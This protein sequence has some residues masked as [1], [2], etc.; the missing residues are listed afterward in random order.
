MI[1]EK[2]AQ[3]PD[4]QEIFAGCI[5]LKE[6]H[7]SFALEDPSNKSP[8]TNVE[9]DS[10]ILSEIG[11]N[12]KSIFNEDNFKAAKQN[13]DNNVHSCYEITFSEANVSATKHFFQKFQETSITLGK[14]IG[15]G[16]YSALEIGTYYLC[17]CTDLTLCSIEDGIGE[18][19]KKS[20][21]RVRDLKES[22]RN[23]G[24]SLPKRKKLDKQLHPK[25][26]NNASQVNIKKEDR[27]A[28]HA[29]NTQDFLRLL[30]KYEK[31]KGSKLKESKKHTKGKK[32]K[33][34]SE[35]RKMQKS[36]NNDSSEQDENSILLSVQQ[37]VK[38]IISEAAVKEK[39][40][41]NC[42]EV[43]SQK[44][45]ASH[46]SADIDK[47][48]A[49]ILNGYKIEKSAHTETKKNPINHNLMTE[50]EAAAE[51][52]LSFLLSE[53]KSINLVDKTGPTESNK[54]ISPDV[55]EKVAAIISELEVIKKFMMNFRPKSP[56]S[57]TDPKI[58]EE[59][60][61][62]T[63]TN[64]SCLSSRTPDDTIEQNNSLDK[65]AQEC[66]PEA[67][68]RENAFRPHKKEVLD[69]S[70]D[71]KISKSI[72]VG[73]SDGEASNSKNKMNRETKSVK[74]SHVKSQ[75]LKKP[76]KK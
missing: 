1:Q 53:I 75:E 4:V 70:H 34:W 33:D 9:N 11:D 27:H 60:A 48:E 8:D 63:L 56:V 35:R 57:I 66:A 39:E 38:E 32:S 21:I 10:K 47:K 5:R 15:R 46:P 36:D 41:S 40:T 13:I 72:S 30:N 55:E 3:S 49:M 22:E 65:E 71:A 25:N 16:L 17:V 18:F 6:D 74:H 12:F 64:E 76:K 73:A 7:L 44:R 68:S 59:K 26:K 67:D 43:H 69:M 37:Q 24:Y 51:E 23:I 2:K 62:P 61:F 31:V 54:N 20:H 52:Q 42:D 28:I 29:K 50:K 58:K 45:K 19:R 14:G